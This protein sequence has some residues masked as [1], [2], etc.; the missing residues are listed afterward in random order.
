[1]ADFQASVL[2]L[3]RRGLEVTASLAQT[4]PKD[5]SPSKGKPP[6]D[7]P[8]FG[9]LLMVT[10]LLCFI[11]LVV[12]VRYTLWTLVATLTMIE[13]TSSDVYLSSAP[14]PSAS[15]NTDNNNEPHSSE[16][17]AMEVAPQPI[18]SHIRRTI[19]HLHAVG[20]FKSR[21]RGFGIFA[22]YTLAY[23]V[24]SQLL[25]ALLA[26][27]LGVELLAQVVASII[28]GVVLAPISLTWTHIIISEPSPLP[29]YRRVS[30]DR[31]VWRT[32]ALPALINEVLSQLAFLLPALCFLALGL[33]DSDKVREGSGAKAGWKAFGILVVTLFAFVAVVLPTKIAYTRIQASMLP[34]DAESIV[35][36]DRTFMGK[37]EPAIL[38]GTGRLG[39]MDAYRSIDRAATRRITFMLG[40]ILLIDVLLHVLFF[41][42]FGAQAYFVVGGAIRKFF[43]G[44]GSS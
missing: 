27:I 26:I 13:D 1:M 14:A 32:I 7:F 4:T 28:T 25:Q 36:F 38:G 30:R 17:G 39:W 43:D 29:W 34:E 33:N 22:S 8:V 42:I 31:K 10:T 11:V 16:Q 20:G 37:V 2:H 44:A 40:K 23:V 21:W 3:A 41:A 15:F 19:R 5:G 18:T 24:I 12:S 35:P 9:S 6:V